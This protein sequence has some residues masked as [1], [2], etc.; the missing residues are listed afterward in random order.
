M[1]RHLTL[2]QRDE[3]LEFYRSIC[4]DVNVLVDIGCRSNHDYHNIRPEAENHLFD[5]CSF[6][7]DSLREKIGNNDKVYLYD[8]GLSNKTEEVSYNEG[9]ESIF[10][11]G[12]ETVR[13]KKFDDAM[14][15]LGIDRKIDFLKID[16]E[17]GEPSILEFTDVIKRIKYVQFEFGYT[18]PDRKSYDIH[19]V[20]E[21]YKDTFDF[22]YMKDWAH[23]VYKGTD[24]ELLTPMSNELCE[25]LEQ[26][27]NG[28][29]GG[30]IVMIYRKDQQ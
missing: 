26:H 15:E 17:G 12:G 1:P 21:Q 10:G 22:F 29:N 24:M 18:W 7:I 25:Q 9:S 2:L 19:N 14:M 28:R 3:E 27:S 11:G 13:V 20:I 23:P 4:E 30:N 8:Y 5:C 16:I 6:H